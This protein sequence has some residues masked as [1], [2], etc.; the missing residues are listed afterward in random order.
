MPIQHIQVYPEKDSYSYTEAPIYMAGINCIQAYKEFESHGYDNR[1]M[2]YINESY[3]NLIE[4]MRRCQEKKQYDPNLNA[5]QNYYF[6]LI[7]HLHR[8]L[9]QNTQ[10]DLATL[11]TT[12]SI[13]Q[14]SSANSR[15]SE[16][17]QVLAGG[18]AQAIN[19]GIPMPA[20]DTS[21]EYSDLADL[22]FHEVRDNEPPPSPSV[23]QSEADYRG[24]PDYIS[25]SPSQNSSEYS[26][27]PVAEL[28]PGFRNR[29]PSIAS[30]ASVRVEEGP[31]VNPREV[32]N[33]Y[34][35]PARSESR[36]STPEIAR[37]EIPKPMQAAQ[38][39]SRASSPEA[40]KVNIPRPT[41]PPRDLYVRQYARPQ[42]TGGI[43]SARLNETRRA[44]QI[45]RDKKQQQQSQQVQDPAR[46]RA[47]ARIDAAAES[48]RRVQERRQKPPGRPEQP[49]GQNGPTGGRR[50]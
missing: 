43:D 50:R 46:L 31:E 48:R 47:Q 41:S 2:F 17:P 49:G 9:I 25:E 15:F 20:S 30:T 3:K 36:A 18:N 27:R 37:R 24:F 22:K 5:W 1:S 11:R 42:N 39:V 21:E 14:A 10:E 16:S 38:P 19:Y 7:E 35:T 8:Q 13:Y 28:P 45:L 12:H 23:A 4:F 26:E 32:F 33:P 29:S 40:P 44:E 6:Q 34:P